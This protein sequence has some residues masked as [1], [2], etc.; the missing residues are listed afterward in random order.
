MWCCEPSRA[1]ASRRIQRDS[2]SPAKEHSPACNLYRR[3]LLWSRRRD[4]RLARH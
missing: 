1:V 2:A 4:S 3:L